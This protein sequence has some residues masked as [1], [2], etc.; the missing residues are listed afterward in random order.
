V[1]NCKKKSENKPPSV[2]ICD[3]LWLLLTTCDYQRTLLTQGKKLVWGVAARN[4]FGVPKTVILAQDGSQYAFW[5][6][7]AGVPN[8]C[9]RHLSTEVWH[10]FWGSE[11]LDRLAVARFLAQVETQYHGFAEIFGVPKGFRGVPN[12]KVAPRVT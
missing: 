3:Y 11:L 1:E 5:P 8:F 2:A 9:L 4:P 6:Q 7:K 12:L 10:G